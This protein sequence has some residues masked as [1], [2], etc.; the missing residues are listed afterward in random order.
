[1]HA[2]KSAAASLGAAEL[3][4]EA[5]FLEKAGKQGDITAING[6]LEKFREH[7]SDMIKNV[8]A[9]LTSEKNRNMA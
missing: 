1:V 7:L 3:S 8:R 2:L 9:A 5:A 6:N 4:K